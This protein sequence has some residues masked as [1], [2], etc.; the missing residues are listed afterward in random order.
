M[1]CPECNSSNF[2]KD[3]RGHFDYICDD[4]GCHWS[5]DECPECGSNNVELVFDDEFD[6]VCIGCGYKWDID[7]DD[8]D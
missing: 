3:Q 5:N 4:C 6:C 2:S 7:D 8:D 1:K